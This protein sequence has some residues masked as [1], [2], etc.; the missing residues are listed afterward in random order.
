MKKK[1][2]ESEPIEV[3]K[4]QRTPVTRKYVVDELDGE[5][6]LE[7][8]PGMTLEEAHLGDMEPVDEDSRDTVEGYHSP[9]SPAMKPYPSQ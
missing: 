2:R 9:Q 1:R 3:Q 4:R 5:L 6:N 8:S 7:D